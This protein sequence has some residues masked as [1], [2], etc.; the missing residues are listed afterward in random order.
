[1]SKGD[2]RNFFAG[3]DVSGQAILGDDNTV[4]MNRQAEAVDLTELVRFAKAVNEALPAL[5]LD[6]QDERSAGA[7]AG[8]IVDAAE[9]PAP[10]HGRLRAAGRTLRA[11][12]E[13]AAANALGAGLLTL[14]SP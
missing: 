2:Q 5:G 13:G 9:G 4:I 1:M 12:V 8:D 11:I 10:D 14:W 3:G 7:L 6:D